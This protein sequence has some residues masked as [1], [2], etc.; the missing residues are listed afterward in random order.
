MDSKVD[1]DAIN[2]YINFVEQ[3]SFEFNFLNIFNDF[4]N[5]FS[6]EFN[7]ARSNFSESKMNTFLENH[8][9]EFSKL[10]DKHIYQINHFKEIEQNG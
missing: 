4:N 7:T 9:D 1:F 2:N 5:I 10:A 8:K 3:N 6:D